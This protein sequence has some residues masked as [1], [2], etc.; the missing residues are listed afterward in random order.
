MT[1]H[2]SGNCEGD[3]MSGV[4]MLMHSEQVRVDADR[5]TELCVRLGESGAEEVM[6]RTMEELAVQLAQ[7]E[8][9]FRRGAVTEMGQLALLIVTGADRIGM[10]ALARVAMDV[11]QCIDAGDEVALSAVLARLLRIAERSLTAI[12]DIQ[13]LSV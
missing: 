7:I 3:K 2:Q 6:C 10:Q 11:V 1:G 5:L 8:K 4:N 12:W 9:E 13:D